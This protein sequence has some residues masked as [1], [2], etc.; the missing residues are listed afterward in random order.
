MCYNSLFFNEG[1]Q[2]SKFSEIFPAFIEKKP[3]ATCEL[4][5]VVTALST[6][7]IALCKAGENAGQIVT[8]Q[9]T[10]AF[11]CI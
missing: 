5:S 8:A 2:E 10:N 6:S 9:V 3:L 1:F 11:I 7:I 4:A